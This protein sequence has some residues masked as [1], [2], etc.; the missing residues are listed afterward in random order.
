MP[1]VEILYSTAV[2]KIYFPPSLPPARSFCSLSMYYLENNIVYSP[3]SKRPIKRRGIVRQ[4]IQASILVGLATAAFFFGRDLTRREH[5]PSLSNDSIKF[6]KD[7]AAE[8][9]YMTS[10]GN[11][12][13][14]T[15]YDLAKHLHPDYN[16]DREIPE[17]IWQSLPV[18]GV[19]YMLVRNEDIQ[20]ARQAIRSVEDRFNHRFCYPWVLLNDQDFSF[21]FRKYIRK[22]TQAPI[23]FGKI[24][25]NVWAYP[26]WI[27]V[28]IAENRML[29]MLRMGIYKAGSPSFHQLLR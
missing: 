27:D 11:D 26:S 25:P 10:I 16:Y 13:I 21:E 3:R 7:D 18:R 29:E 24:N 4:L 5:I 20:G 8:A 19:L 15:E 6:T 12:T 2:K 14:L 9:P 17:D 28:P 1:L 22:A 23:F